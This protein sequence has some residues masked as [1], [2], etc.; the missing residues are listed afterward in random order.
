MAQKDGNLAG[1]N[2]PFGDRSYGGRAR[3]RA[4]RSVPGKPAGRRTHGYGGAPVDGRR[5][6]AEICTELSEQ[7]KESDREH[8]R[9]YRPTII[10]ALTR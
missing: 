8:V 1:M 5:T 7:E 6:V 4:N 2:S 10:D 3:R 9:K